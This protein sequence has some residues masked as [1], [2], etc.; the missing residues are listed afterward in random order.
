MCEISRD[1]FKVNAKRL[2]LTYSQVP[3]DLP[4]DAY[5]TTKN[6]GCTVCRK[7]GVT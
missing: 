2:F 6:W 4:F 1:P 7:C 5:V 3:H